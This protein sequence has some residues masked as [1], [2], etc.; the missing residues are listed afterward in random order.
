MRKQRTHK[1]GIA[2]YLIEPAPHDPQ[3]EHLT[4]IL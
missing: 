2:P 1:P 3:S 4:H